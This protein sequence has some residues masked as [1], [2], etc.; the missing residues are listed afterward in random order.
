MW[1]FCPLALEALTPRAGIVENSSCIQRA[2]RYLQE[3]RDH[4]QSQESRQVQ[5]ELLQGA[6]HPGID[7]RRAGL[8]AG[9]VCNAEPEG[10]RSGKQRQGGGQAGVLVQAH[11]VNG[12]YNQGQQQEQPREIVNHIHAGV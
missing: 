6:G 3:Q 10:G 7:T 5:A 9:K 1:G 11:P 2:S 4:S 12:G 8:K